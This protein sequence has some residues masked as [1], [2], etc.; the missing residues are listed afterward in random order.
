MKFF[1]FLLN[2]FSCLF[3]R[4]ICLRV[5]ILLLKNGGICQMLR[6]YCFE[7]SKRLNIWRRVQHNLKRLWTEYHWT[8]HI[9]HYIHLIHTTTVEKRSKTQRLYYIGRACVEGFQ[10]RSDMPN[11][12][13]TSCWQYVLYDFELE[14]LQFNLLRLEER[15]QIYQIYQIFG[16]RE[17]IPRLCEIEREPWEKHGWNCQQLSF[18]VQARYILK[19]QQGFWGFVCGEILKGV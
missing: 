7:N 15:H 4:A 2:S 16:M 11:N 5:S 6:Q 10:F 9:L 14:H 12:Y 3:L 18:P 1:H 17:I 8:N 13:G 19:I